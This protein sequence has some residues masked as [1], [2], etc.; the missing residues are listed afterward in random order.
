MAKDI[1]R[2]ADMVNRKETLEQELLLKS[3]LV[4]KGKM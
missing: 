2:N 1:L 4:S 3:T